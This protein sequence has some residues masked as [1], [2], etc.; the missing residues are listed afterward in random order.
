MQMSQ[1]QWVALLWLAMASTAIAGERKVGTPPKDF[2][3]IFNQGYAGDA[4]P[5]DKAAFERQVLS[6]KKAHYNVILCKYEDW[7]AEICKK[8]G[9][10]ILVDLLVPEHHVYK[11]VEGAMA[12]C[13]KLQGN[14][15]IWGYHLWSDRIGGSVNG[16]NRDINNVQQ[17]DPTHSTYVGSYNGRA[18]DG[19]KNPDAIAYY[20]FHWKRGGH[21]RH[22]FR[23]QAAARKTDSVFLRYCQ[24]DPGMIGKGNYNR[25]L[26]TI[27]TSIAFGLKGYTF[28]YRNGMINPKT[29]DWGPLGKDLARVNAEVMPLG[30]ELIKLG[31]PNGTYSTPVTKTAKD[32]PTGK[33]EPSVPAELK[34]V[35]AGFPVEIKKGEVLLGAFE[36][37]KKAPVLFLANHNAY[38]S[39]EMLITMKEP[40]KSVSLFDR[41]KKSWRLLKPGSNG[42]TFTIPPAGGELIR[43][44]R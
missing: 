23:A 36:D 6:L 29:G 19:L 18:L 14:K 7:R 40:F 3:I 22:L 16:R 30:S 4:I 1:L 24:S 17:W 8:H 33:K 11:N 32:R 13:K 39:Q 31:N 37:S 2:A 9:L 28:H 10:K 43:L 41:S 5:K 25:V 35:P 27:S 26:Y 15:V 20:D 12:L 21:W 34:P 44:A 42:I 38:Q